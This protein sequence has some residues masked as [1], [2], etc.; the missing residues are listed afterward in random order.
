M[1]RTACHNI[2]I[3]AFNELPSFLFSKA[4]RKTFV[5]VLFLSFVWWFVQYHRKHFQ[6]WL[7]QII[8][9][10]IELFQMGWM[11]FQSF[12]QC[13]HTFMSYFTVGQ[14]EERRV[15]FQKVENQFNNRIHIC[16]FVLEI[17]FGFT[18]FV[19]SASLVYSED[20]VVRRRA[21]SPLSL[22]DH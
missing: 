13:G 18:F 12:S 11:W 16:V 10:E 15:D 8:L 22:V 2:D 6:V 4:L 3:N 14:P 1:L 21:S 9:T 20:F 17:W 5:L 7:F 19:T